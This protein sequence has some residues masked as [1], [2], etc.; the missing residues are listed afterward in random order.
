MKAR[1][2]TLVTD[3]E[4]GSLEIYSHSQ[5]EN[6][7]VQAL[8]P[9]PPA[10]FLPIQ[11]TI[12]QINTSINQINTSVQRNEQQSYNRARNM[13]ANQATHPIYPIVNDAGALPTVGVLP[14]TKGA[15][16]SSNVPAL[17]TLC[18]HYGIPRLGLNRDAKLAAVK[19]YLHIA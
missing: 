16:E 17:N 1:D 2:N 4:M 10:W 13:N 8:P 15:L 6:Y 18:D 19:E 7:I 14:A 11:A 3:A 9:A 12:N 5:V